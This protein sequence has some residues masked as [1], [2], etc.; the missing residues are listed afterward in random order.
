MEKAGVECVDAL[1]VRRQHPARMLR[2]WE[3]KPYAMLHCPFREVMLLD[4]DN[5]PVRDPSF[6]F[7]TGL[8][9][10]TGSL[11]WPDLGRLGPER[12]IRRICA[13]DYRDEP[14]F[15]SGQMVVNKE[16][17]WREL[18]LTMHL[19]EYSDFWSH[20]VSLRHGK[21]RRI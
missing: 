8:Y 15:E 4:A 6:L 12:A 13:V 10:E 21:G 11:F 5:H 2:G 18:Q 17:C 9:Q 3:V 16:R 1:E 7:D 20:P 14:E 19:N